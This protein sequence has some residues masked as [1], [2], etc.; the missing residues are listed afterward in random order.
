[1]KSS[2]KTLALWAFIIIGA[3]IV[4]QA[5]EQ[6]AQNEIKDFTFSTFTQAVEDGLVKEVTI[7]KEK[8]EE[9]V[10]NS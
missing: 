7:D 2:Q 6:R 5:Y 4:F 8:E 1:M 10:C 3:L 9:P